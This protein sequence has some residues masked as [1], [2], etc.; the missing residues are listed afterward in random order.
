[1]SAAVCL[2]KFKHFVMRCDD[3]LLLVDH[4]PLV[5][6]LGDRRLEDIDNMSLLKLKERTL[7]CKFKV[8]HVLGRL[9]K[10]PNA[11]SRYPQE[12]AELFLED[13]VLA[14]VIDEV[15]AEVHTAITENW[16]SPD[17]VNV[18][19]SMVKEATS[20][21]LDLSRLRQ[22]IRNGFETTPN[23]KTLPEEL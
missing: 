15:E 19:W 5:K 23:V 1:L 3:L 10:M 6:L 14:M 11:G 22:E 20:L 16:K 7:P 4:K 9:H 18:T 12:S 13:E 21:D 2:R 8:V 17:I